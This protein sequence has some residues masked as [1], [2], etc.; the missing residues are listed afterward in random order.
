[1]PTAA[2]APP[3]SAHTA[4]GPLWENHSWHQ[5]TSQGSWKD[6]YQAFP[7][8]GGSL[9]TKQCRKKKQGINKVRESNSPQNNNVI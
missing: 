8:C 1:M 3:P 9:G 7:C 5:S 4:Q 2:P 6:V